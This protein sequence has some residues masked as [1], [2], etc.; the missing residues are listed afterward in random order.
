MQGLQKGCKDAFLIGGTR[1]VEIRKRPGGGLLP[2]RHPR[3]LKPV[4][5]VASA[6]R[7]VQALGCDAAC[8]IRLE[9]RGHRGD[10]L[11]HLLL[12]C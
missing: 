3:L 9:Y 7:F 6:W 8:G 12:S 5:W 11:L 4:D 2:L 1:G 10:H